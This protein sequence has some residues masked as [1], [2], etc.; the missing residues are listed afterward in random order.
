MS[1]IDDHRAQEATN[2]LSFDAI[3]R[4]NSTSVEA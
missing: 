2:L 4:F 3:H 1:L